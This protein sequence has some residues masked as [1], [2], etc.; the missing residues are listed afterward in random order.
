MKLSTDFS[1]IQQRT[2]T[3]ICWFIYGTLFTIINANQE[4]IT[5]DKYGKGSCGERVAGKS[6]GKMK[7]GYGK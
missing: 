7:K 5:M 1:R 2:R 4:E 3:I 6:K